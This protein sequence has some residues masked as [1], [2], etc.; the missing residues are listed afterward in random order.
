MLIFTDSLTTFAE[1]MLRHR[2]C[3]VDQRQRYLIVVVV[4]TLFAITLPTSVVAKPRYDVHPG[5]VEFI[6]PVAKSTNYVISVSADG[7][8]RV[9]F[10]VDRGT[11]KT[12]YTARGRVSSRGIE[13][14]F[15]VF[16]RIDIKL[17][18]VRYSSDRP[19]KRRCKGRAPLY[20]EGT[21]RG[22]IEFSRQGDVP[23]VSSKHGR[24]YFER[25]F[26]Q[27]CERRRR[28]SKP[29][30]EDKAKDKIEVSLLAVHGKGEGRT[31]FVQAINF[32]LRRN[33]IRSWGV[34]AVA[35]FERREG[36]RI[37]KRVSTSLSHRS[38]DMSARGQTPETVD[39]ELPEPFAGHAVY[40][41]NSDSSSSWTGDFSIGLTGADRIPL[42]GPSFSAVLCRGF[43][44]AMLNRCLHNSRSTPNAR[45]S[46]AMAG[47]VGLA[48]PPKHL[49]A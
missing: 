49:N 47:S 26:R 37:T 34:L 12:D 32:A 43:Y 22:A 35:V 45:D 6:L 14:K 31:V 40:S 4:I 10:T 20:Q 15:G 23:Q 3:Q 39:I 5:S 24:V 30:G 17:H 13:A 25:R 7:Q 41:R 36:V 42:T 2:S 33:P 11:S 21:Y 29:S 19:R 28:Q 9:H 1:S 44:I 18:L 48:D 38:F 46:R 27:V 16:G 8:Q